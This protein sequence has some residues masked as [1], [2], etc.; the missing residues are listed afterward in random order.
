MITV[1]RNAGGEIA[2]VY[3]LMGFKR[4][5]ESGWDAVASRFVE[6]EAIHSLPVGDGAGTNAA[7][8]IAIDSLGAVYPQ[9]NSRRLAVVMPTGEIVATGDK[10]DLARLTKSARRTIISALTRQR[11]VSAKGGYV[12][13]L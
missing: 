8:R 13:H 2:V 4:I 6:A 12:V 5:A 7:I 10:I 9:C 1:L 3:S 11:R